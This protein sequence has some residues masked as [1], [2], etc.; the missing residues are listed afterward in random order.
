M[1][2]AIDTAPALD[3]NPQAMDHRVEALRAYHALY[4]PLF[5]R[6]E[7]REWAAK[8]LHGLLLALPRK[9]LEPIVLTL[10]GPH[11]KA[12]RTLQLFISEGSWQDEVLLHRHWQEVDQAWGE[13]DGVLILDGSDFLNQGQASAGVKRQDWNEVGKRANGQAGVFVGYASRQGDTLLDRRLSLPQEWIE[14][15][16]YAERRRRC[17]IA[18][19]L[20]F[21]TKP[22]LG[23][24]MVEAICQAGTVRARGVVGDEAFGCDTRTL[25][26]LDACGLWSLAEGPHD[27]RV[28]QQRPATAIPSWTG[29]GRPPM[30]RR[31]LAGEAAPVTVAPLAALLPAAHWTRQTIKE[32]SKGSLV[33]DFAAVR[34]IAVREG[35]PGPAVWVVLRRNPLT[36]ELKTALSN[37]PAETPRA[38]LVRVRGMR[39]PIET[40]VEDGKQYLGRGDYEVRSWR[41]WHHH[42]TRVF[43]AQFFLVRLCR[44]LKNTPRG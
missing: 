9:S 3:L 13:D 39:W 12:V 17:A 2:E 36:G 10:E 34:L 44:R 18:S 8:S 19:T 22:P 4:R 25:D 15:A 23:W 35:W 27:T 26:R 41:G 43:L 30:R 37:A 16:A 28:W 6:R 21:K 7:P 5:Q 24:E 11:P 32:G 29:H 40:C 14:E 31:V 20:G 33:A 1:T 42:M 38:E